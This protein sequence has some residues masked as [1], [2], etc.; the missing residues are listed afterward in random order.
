MWTAACKVKRETSNVRLGSS[1]TGQCEEQKGGGF[2]FPMK[3]CH[4]DIKQWEPIEDMVRS[5][6]SNHSSFK[7]DS[8]L[9]NDHERDHEQRRQV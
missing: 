1:T 6:P 3:N 4:T 5:F 8:S 9:Q 7:L 2:S